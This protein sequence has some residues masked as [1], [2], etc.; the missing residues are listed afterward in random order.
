MYQYL[1]FID[2]IQNVSNILINCKDIHA[3]EYLFSHQ[4]S[5]MKKELKED[6][7][8]GSLMATGMLTNFALLQ[9]MRQSKTL[10]TMVIVGLAAMGGFFWFLS[11]IPG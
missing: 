5:T 4:G 8:V 6:I 10:T 9:S 7:A 3:L 1:V 2:S 11:S